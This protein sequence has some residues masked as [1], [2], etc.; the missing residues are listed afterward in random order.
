MVRE[1]VSFF[2]LF[3]TDD[4]NETNE[5]ISQ[6]LGGPSV[7]C[8]GDQTVVYSVQLLELS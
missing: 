2:F 1:D 7:S 4:V 8:S 3:Y 5:D 6:N